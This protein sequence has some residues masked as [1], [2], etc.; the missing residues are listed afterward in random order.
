MSQA[1]RSTISGLAALSLGLAGLAA[2]AVTAVPAAAAPNGNG[3]GLGKHDR[4][5]LADAVASGDR[6]VTLLIASRPGAN[7]TV[8]SGITG[9]GA[10]VAK[11]DDDVGYLRAVVPTGKAEQAA[12]LAGVQAADL[13]EVVPLDDPAPGGSQAPTP[14]TPPSASTP[15]DNPYLPIGDTGASQFMAAHPTWD[16]RGT[17]IGILDTGVDLDHPALRTTTTGLPKVTDWVTYTDPFADDDPTWVSM[18]DQ[19]SG[20]SFTYQTVTYTAPAAASYRIGLFNERDPRLGGEVGSDV[21]RDGNPTG[22]SGLFAVLWNTATNNVYVD[23]DQDRSFADEQAMTDFRVRRDIGHFGKDAPDTDVHET[24]PFVVQTDGKDKVVNIGIVSGE[25]GTH[26]AGIAAGNGLFGGAMTGAAPGAQVKSVRVCMFIAGCTAH[27]LVEGMIWVVKQGNVDVVNMS[28]GGLPALNDGNNTRAVLYNRL[29]DQYDAQIFISAGNNGAGLNTVGDPAVASKVVASGAYASQESWQKNYGSDSDLADTIQGYSSRGPREDGGFKPEVL[30]PGSAVST[31]PMW[32]PGGPVAGTYDLP[33]G[34]GMLNGTSM[35]SPQSAGAGALLV[36]AAKQAG[37]QSKPAQLRQALFSSARFLPDYGAYEQGNG[38]IDVGAAWDVLKKTV[39]PVSI[40][41]SVA[42][43]SVLSGFLATPGTGVGIFDREGVKAGDSYTRTYTFTR[44]SGGAKAITYAASWVGND[45]TFSGP[46]S[47]SLPLN[48][49][50][51]YAVTVHPQSAGAHS[52]ILNLDDPATPGVDEQTLNTVVAAESFTAANGYSITHAG[53]IGRN[54]TTSYFFDV[55][56]GTPA[57]KVDL[58][59]GGSTPGAGQIRFLRFHP[60]GLGL[61]DNSSLSCYN[62]SSGSCSGSPTS[63]TTSNPQAGVWEVVVEARRTSDVAEAPYS[64]TASILGASVS[65]S[66][67]TIASATLG[68]PVARS[69]TLTNL[70][71]TF[72]GRAV[73]T[74]LG[75]ARSATPTIT[76]GVLQQRLVDV[77]AGSTSLRA[78]IG[79]TSDPGADLDLYVYNCTT[80]TCLLAGQSADGDSEE[81]VTIANPAAGAW[82]TLV[83]GYAV[84]SGSTTFGYTDV[85]TNPAFGS[86]SVTDANASRPAGSSWTAPGTVTAAAAPAA[87]RVLLGNVQ[88]RTDGNVLVGSGDVV[89]QSV[90]P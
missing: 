16:G 36:S 31:T 23:T 53:T 81:S 1:H 41:S 47:V 85:F 11:R 12:R 58:T 48:T 37:V 50:T 79:G 19:V 61:E 21:N 27:A 38:L 69:Y 54:R 45:G 72:T 9:L 66:T 64:L 78:T 77:S 56:A 73:G 29:V 67:D 33:A 2:V 42:V 46:A 86:V 10:T 25:H 4:E 90:T 22:S 5:L 87:G 76:T 6:T 24:M 34:Y 80:G 13:D 89:V 20:S 28:I 63:R 83:D 8:V 71:G 70:F 49:P 74:T 88:V 68:V 44:T 18:A 14:Q 15:N 60:Y 7:R 55:P 59:G 52:A 75:S 43:H 57:F 39:K 35:A 30:A 32:Q 84:P 51:T 3:H 40:T 82:V 62:P 65:P 26:V 17:T